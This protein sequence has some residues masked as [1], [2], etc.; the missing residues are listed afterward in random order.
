[1]SDSAARTWFDRRTVGLVFLGVG[2]LGVVVSLVA[3]VV[4]LRF[5]DQLDTALT[6]SVGV[7]AE[8]VDALGATV[9]LAGETL[10]DVNVILEGTA[11]TTTRVSRALADTEE[12][13]LGTADLSEDQIVGSLEAVDATL[14]ALIQVAAVI[15][16]TLSALSVVPLGPDYDPE[17]TFDDSLRAIQREF[18]GLP[19]ALREQAGLIR[20]G[21]GELGTTREGTAAIAQDL[22]DLRG[23][24][25]ASNELLERYA[26]TAAETQR[27][28]TMDAGLG[29][30]L[31]WARVLAL[32]LGL[33]VAAGQCVPLGTGWLLLRPE[34]ARAFLAAPDVVSDKPEDGATGH[35]T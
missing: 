4:G 21:A 30:Q 33:T 31:G 11:Q 22:D 28:V 27:L 3:T 29:R 1:M 9:E 6:D 23:T 35:G 7:A 15:D 12:I 18:D 17:E 19:E 8:A 26:A 24:L 10:A 25:A 16:R 5:L 32:L 34:L 20:A 14:P 2:G 13:L